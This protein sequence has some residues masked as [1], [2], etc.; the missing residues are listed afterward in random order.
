MDRNTDAAETA[1]L[2]DLRRNAKSELGRALFHALRYGAV[3]MDQANRI[4]LI[5]APE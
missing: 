2:N 5:L 4:A 3:S 1:R